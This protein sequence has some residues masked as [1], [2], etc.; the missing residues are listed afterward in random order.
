MF[1]P[2]LKPVSWRPSLMVFIRRLKPI[3]IQF[4][5]AFMGW[6]WNDRFF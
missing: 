2:R 6:F 4:A 5:T 1:M 3:N